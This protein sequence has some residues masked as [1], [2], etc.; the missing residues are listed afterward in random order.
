M[1]D[2]PDD[3]VER[4]LAAYSAETFA[5]WTAERH[6]AA[7]RA[8]GRAFVEWEREQCG[9]IVSDMIGQDGM[10]DGVTAYNCIRTRGE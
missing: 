3:V 2:I 10:C 4:A 6:E 5:G 8:A 1:T 9:E 7:L